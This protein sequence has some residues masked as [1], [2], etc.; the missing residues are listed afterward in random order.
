MLRKYSVSVTY[1]WLNAYS[2]VGE[3]YI[4]RGWR[5]LLEFARHVLLSNSVEQM[6]VYR[7]LPAR[8]VS[9]SACLA[10]PFFVIRSMTRTQVFHKIPGS[11]K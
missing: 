1:C 4:V 6:V 3:I 11:F 7:S 8:L 9:L 2:P 10:Y 5:C